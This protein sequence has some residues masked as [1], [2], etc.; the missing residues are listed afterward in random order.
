MNTARLAPTVVLGG[1]V[2][3]LVASL[4]A[5][6]RVWGDVSGNAGL[7]S[8]ATSNTTSQRLLDPYSLTHVSHGIIPYYLTGLT[9][10]SM[11]TRLLV[12]TAIE[13]AWEIFENTPA[14]IAKYRTQPA[15]ADY[16]GDS[17]LNSF[18]DLGS[19]VAGFAMAHTLGSTV[20]L[21]YLAGSELLL[22][23]TIKDNLL[24]SALHIFK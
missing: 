21:A 17:V 9:G 4:R 15:S 6:G 10:L 3:V 1:M 7:W 24:L 12:S 20:S 19:M 14:V 5:M 2:A 11:P 22:Y 23:V 18:G 13:T 8:S 16:L